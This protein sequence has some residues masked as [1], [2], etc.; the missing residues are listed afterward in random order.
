MNKS[1]LSDLHFPNVAGYRQDCLDRAYGS[2]L[3]QVTD[4]EW[5]G[6]RRIMVTY[7]RETSEK[8]GVTDKD[9]WSHDVAIQTICSDFRNG[10]ITPMPKW[11]AFASW[12]SYNGIVKHH[13]LLVCRIIDAAINGTLA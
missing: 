11:A 13:P 3:E 1:E 5:N 2:P 4:S 8:T 12:L 10:C 6:I 7:I 9:A